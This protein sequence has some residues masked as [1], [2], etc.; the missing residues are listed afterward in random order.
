MKTWQK[1]PGKNG[2]QLCGVFSL[3]QILPPVLRYLNNI[4]SKMN[5]DLKIKIVIGY[6]TIQ[7]RAQGARGCGVCRGASR[8]GQIT[9]KSCR[10]L[11]Q[12]Y[13]TPLF[14]APKSVFS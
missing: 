10:F 9:T 11:P 2:D 6:A 4:R 5:R 1:L 3:G 12:P 7:V 13:F 8:F 14:L